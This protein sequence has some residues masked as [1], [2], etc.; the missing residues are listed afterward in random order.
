LEGGLRLPLA[1][2]CR[3]RPKLG[4][5]ARHDDDSDTVVRADAVALDGVGT[6]ARQPL[7]RLFRREAVAA[8]PELGQDLVSRQGGS[9]GK[10]ELLPDVCCASTVSI[11][12]RRKPPPRWPRL[13]PGSLPACCRGRSLCT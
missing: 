4:P 7:L 6:E 11:M 9:G 12:S 13:F 3:D 10:V 1:E 2:L 5:G 8:R